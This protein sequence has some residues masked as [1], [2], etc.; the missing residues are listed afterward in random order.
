VA[1][2]YAAPGDC[3]GVDAFYD[4]LAERTPVERVETD[5]RV[6]FRV[7]VRADASQ[8]TGSLVVE[9]DGER[10]TPREVTGATCDDVVRA[11]A[12][13]GSLAFEHAEAP[14]PHVA[15]SER[16][17]VPTPTRMRWGAGVA[18][19]VDGYAAPGAIP[20]AGAFVEAAWPSGPS[21]RL[22]GTVSAFGL[23]RVTQAGSELESH[24]HWLTARVDGCPAAFG[25][26]GVDLS[27][28]ASLSVGAL[29]GVG[30]GTADAHA[31]TRAWVEPQGRARLRV[32]VSKRVALGCDLS[33]GFPLLR[34]DFSFTPSAAMYRAP[35]MVV[36]GGLWSGVF[37]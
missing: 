5:A 37:F 17:P 1:I 12:L 20:G 30:R 36:G 6:I 8:F 18:L 19:A 33:I 10:S 15:A 27:A 14:E 35:P 24:F 25:S 3:G 32:R 7:T 21:L 13:V 16:A 34:S 26:H 28:C 2:V 4:R 11:L 22:T 23:A 29:A 9:R 31:E